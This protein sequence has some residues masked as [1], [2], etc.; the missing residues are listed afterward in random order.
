MG[1]YK[2]ERYGAFLR[3][4]DGGAAIEAMLVSRRLVRST[5]INTVIGRL[6]RSGV[7]LHLVEPE[8]FRAVSGGTRA[9]GIVA[10]VRQRWVRPDAPAD[11]LWLGLER[12]R[13]PGNLGCILRTCEAAGVRGVLIGP[14]CDPFDPNV[15]GSSMGGE[16]G[17]RFVRA[18]AAGAARWARI[19]GMAVVASSPRGEVE[20]DRFDWPANAL[21]WLGEEREGLRDPVLDGA[22]ARVR[23]RMTGR[24]DSLNVAT[25]TGILIYEAL[26]ARR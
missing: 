6:R 1:L 22:D 10:I 19:H 4:V 20:H 24:A 17:L 8:S 11:G 18:D 23:I 12:I 26:R 2:I 16:L 7:P 25:A 15:I 3:A 9:S 14:G 5:V 13:S 21:L